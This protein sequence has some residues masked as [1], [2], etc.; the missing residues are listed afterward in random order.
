MDQQLKYYHIKETS[1]SAS[2]KK[3]RGEGN[4]G[5]NPELDLKSPPSVS[6][7]PLL[8]VSAALQYFT[9]SVSLI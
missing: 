4:D 1:V 6:V 9:I 5:G 7:D 3:V 2:G 8:Q